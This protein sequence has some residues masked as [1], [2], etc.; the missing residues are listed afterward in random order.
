[1]EVQKH[2]SYLSKIHI[3]VSARYDHRKESSHLE[4]FW[5]VAAQL[6][7]VF[8]KEAGNPWCV[9]VQ[10]LKTKLGSVEV[11]TSTLQTILGPREQH[12]VRPVFPRSIGVRTWL[13]YSSLRNC[14]IYLADS[15]PPTSELRA[16]RPVAATSRIPGEGSW[17]SLAQES[18]GFGNRCK[19]LSR[20]KSI[21]ESPS[22]GGGRKEWVWERQ[23][24]T[25]T[26]ICN[27]Y[28]A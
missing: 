23:E 16:S 24:S 2:G 18:Q 22:V 3:L 4:W 26:S 9:L 17:T 20:Y 25:N 15:P 10:S 27:V 1:M 28:I 19:S 13:W 7:N 5:D 14:S 12:G 21:H 11:G 8:S 6:E